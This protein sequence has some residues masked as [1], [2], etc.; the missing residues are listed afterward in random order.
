MLFFSQTQLTVFSLAV[1]K[2]IFSVIAGTTL[3]YIS[4]CVLTLLTQAS[5]LPERIIKYVAYCEGLSYIAVALLELIL[6]L[7]Y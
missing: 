1:F 5:P 6:F 7:S 2:P 4:V 3:A